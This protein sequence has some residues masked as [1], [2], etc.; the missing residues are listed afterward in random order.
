MRSLELLPLRGFLLCP[1]CS[2]RLTGSASKGKYG[3]HHYYHCQHPC[4]WR[5]N[6]SVVNISFAEY[7][8]QFIPKNGVA[9]LF[10]EIVNDLYNE[11]SASFQGHRKRLIAEITDQHNRI[12]RARELL[13]NGTLSE[14]EYTNLKLDGDQKLMKLEATLS[15]L[16]TKGKPEVDVLGII[17]RAL[18]NLKKLDIL[19]LNADI[20]GKRAILSSIFYEK[21]TFW[22]GKHRTPKLNETASLIH[23]IN[24]KLVNKKSRLRANVRP[25]SARVSPTRFELISLVPETKILSIELRRRERK[26]MD[27]FN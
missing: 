11:E 15:E 19:Y 18:E 8:K 22:E 23:Q 10:T 9:E 2:K 12:N 4:K 6:A 24:N 13:L 27:S 16:Q 26:Y 14:S 20:E 7:L 1:L 21:W 25:Q 5:A 3:H 17:Y